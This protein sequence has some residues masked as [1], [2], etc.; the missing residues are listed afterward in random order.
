MEVQQAEGGNLGEILISLGYITFDDLA[1]ALSGCLN[2]EYISLSE[3]E[4]DPEVVGIIGEENRSDAL[5][6]AR[7]A[8]EDYPTGKVPEENLRRTLAVLIEEGEWAAAEARR[9]HEE[10]GIRPE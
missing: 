6:N 8:L 4:I 5:N 3:V 2:V 9:Y 7:T 1:Q 10:V